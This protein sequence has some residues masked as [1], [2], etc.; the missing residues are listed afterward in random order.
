LLFF[1]S[2]YFLLRKH[3]LNFFQI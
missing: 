2:Y 3:I 1:S